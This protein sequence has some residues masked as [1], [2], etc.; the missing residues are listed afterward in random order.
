MK[1]FVVNAAL[2][3]LISACGLLAYDR[4]V[5]RPS[6]VVGLVDVAEIYRLKEAE[7][8]AAA[9]AG[10]SD[11]ER[12]RAA[13]VATRFARRLPEALEELPRECRCLV[14]MKNAVAGR[15]SSMIDLTPL[16]KA[17]VGLQ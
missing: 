10:G 7:Y 8:A 4:L 17:K 15:T 9:T 2:S 11:D 3:L 16:L 1:S 13:E 12:T 14:V 5:F 6:Q